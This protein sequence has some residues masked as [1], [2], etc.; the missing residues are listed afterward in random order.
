[1]RL[2]TSLV[3]LLLCVVVVVVVVVVVAGVRFMLKALAKSVQP[4]FY[5][6]ILTFLCMLFF[7]LVGI[8]LF[9][10]RLHGGCYADYI[11]PAGECTAN[12]FMHR[13]DGHLLCSF[14]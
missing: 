14:L 7:A 12:G 4:L 8:E 2:G 10:G 9:Q 6:S 1:M 13:V 5:L 11:S 3:A